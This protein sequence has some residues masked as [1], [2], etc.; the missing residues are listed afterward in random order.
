MFRIPDRIRLFMA[1]ASTAPLPESSR[2]SARDKLLRK[3]Q[4]N[5]T[6]N[7]KFLVVNHPKSGGTWLRVMLSRLY[8]SRYGLPP[9]RIVKSDEFYNID[10]TMPRFLVSNAYYSYESETQRVLDDPAEMATKKVILL[11]RNPLDVVVSWYLQFTGR[12]KAYKRE[13]INSTLQNPLTALDT[14]TM[15]EFVT[16]EELGLAGVIKFHNLWAERLSKDDNGM[17]LHY[18]A[19][20]A[21]P[22]K[23]MAELIAFMEEPFNEK[24]IAD[25]VAFGDFD[26]MRK[27]ELSGY[28][29]NSS[30]ALRTKNDPNK[31]KVR[32]GKV[33]G[34]KDYFNTSQLETLES[35]V[36]EKLS[37]LL[38]VSHGSQQ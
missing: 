8:Q 28:F 27:M 16:H 17:I 34:Y 10:S 21:E 36:E 22:H 23:A 15:W 4:A 13:M 11:A 31:L 29:K 35:M 6:R 12:T 9:R 38:K 30:M 32:K 26:N 20:R 3:Q 25:A 24:E 2:I 1:I 18:E 19:L 7:A 33:G 37:P 14:T 5:K